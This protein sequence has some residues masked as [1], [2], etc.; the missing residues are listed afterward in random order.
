M[1][2][3]MFHIQQRCTVTAEAIQLTFVILIKNPTES[4]ARA[5]KLQLCDLASPFVFILH[6]ISLSLR[7]RF[8]PFS[9]SPQ[10]LH[11]VYNCVCSW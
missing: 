2:C 8:R 3:L 6:I 4:L 10:F 11:F 5:G 9:G 1:H 7:P